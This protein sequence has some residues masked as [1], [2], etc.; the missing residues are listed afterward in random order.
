MQSTETAKKS[1]LLPRTLSAIVLAPV[2]I[3]MIW[4]GGL[5][6]EL[7]MLIVGV[8]AAYEWGRLC[9]SPSPKIST[10]GLIAVVVA[11]IVEIH[12]VEKDV[13]LLSLIIMIACIGCFGFFLQIPQ[14]GRYV[15]GTIY[16]GLGVSCLLFLRSA[17]EEKGLFYVIT[18][19][20]CVWGT[21]I[22]A[23][24]AGRTFGG[25]KLAPSISPKKTWSGLIGGMIASGVVLSLCYGLYYQ[26]HFAPENTSLMVYG[27]TFAMGAVIAV[28]AQAGDFFESW[29]KR[30]AGVKDSGK[31]I[32]GHGGV[33]DRVDGLL[34]GAT[35]FYCFYSLLHAT[36]L[37]V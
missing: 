4:Y 13:S 37:I 28:F 12:F 1:D 27:A 34:S 11:I 2:V 7:L 31:L 19:F 18:I 17:G 16:I 3:G 24:F 20:L 6:F 33:L 30:Q 36:N 23:Y 25:P 29:A 32:P 5:A 21:D 26:P 8:A 14:I 9:K 22:F 35:A 15:L 10:L